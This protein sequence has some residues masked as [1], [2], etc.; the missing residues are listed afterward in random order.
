MKSTTENCNS[1]KKIRREFSD[2]G[3][4]LKESH[5]YGAFKIAISIVFDSGKKIEETYFINCKMVS[6]KKYEKE[7]IAYSDMPA[8]DTVLEDSG[9]LILKAAKLEQKEKL[10]NT[11]VVIAND[12]NK[13]LKDDFCR[14]LIPKA[15]EIS[16]IM[17]N[18]I[19][20]FGEYCENKSK[21]ILRLFKTTGCKRIWAIDFERNNGFIGTNKLVIELS[22]N[23]EMRKMLY[24]RINKIIL[25]KGYDENVDDGEDY[26]FVSFK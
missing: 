17:D 26:L 24:S 14:S 10:K 2:G 16:N 18:N 25:N 12:T 23:S 4:L 1:G 11:K 6:K 9:G 5:S 13:K 8:A 21:A 20:I 7:R 19:L 22:Q 15:L 3:I